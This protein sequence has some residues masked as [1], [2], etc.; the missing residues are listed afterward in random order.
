ME[1]DAQQAERFSAIDF[2]SERGDRLRPQRL[3]RRRK[4]DQVARMR[5]DWRDSGFPGCGLESRDLGGGQRAGAPLARVLAEDLERLTP[6]YLRAR[7]CE[8]KTAGHRHMRAETRHS[9]I[10]RYATCPTRRSDRH[11]A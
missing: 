1:H 10:I 3:A 7:D 6:V 9:A 5:D 4:I 2:L 8:G 11:P